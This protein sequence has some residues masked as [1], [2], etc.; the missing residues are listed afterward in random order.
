MR[1]GKKGGEGDLAARTGLQCERSAPVVRRRVAV[2]IVDQE[3]VV[4]DTVLQTATAAPAVNVPLRDKEDAPD[5]A[6]KGNSVSRTKRSIISWTVREPEP[7]SSS[8]AYSA[9]SYAMCQSAS[10]ETRRRGQRIGLGVGERPPTCSKFSSCMC[11]TTTPAVCVG[12][13]GTAFAATALSAK[14]S[15]LRIIIREGRQTTA[16]VAAGH[17][18]EPHVS[19][20]A[21][22]EI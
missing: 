7:S 5:W 21:E 3:S 17:E 20:G 16:P 11:P 12:G 18:E 9:S 6:S 13:T 22:A 15:T 8:S 4:V 14:P 2:A 1:T 10:A 19:A